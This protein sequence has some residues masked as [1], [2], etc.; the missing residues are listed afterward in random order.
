MSGVGPTLLRVIKRCSE[1]AG[2]PGRGAA[3]W[4]NWTDC[5]LTAAWVQRMVSAVQVKN[6]QC[7]I[8]TR[9]RVGRVGAVLAASSGCSSPICLNYE[10]AIMRMIV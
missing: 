7:V 5:C 2:R 4:T 10:V 6:A 9:S 8:A 3:V 1:I